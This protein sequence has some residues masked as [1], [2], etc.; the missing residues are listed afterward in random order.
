MVVL[1]TRDKAAHFREQIRGVHQE[2]L[3]GAAPLASSSSSIS[4]EESGPGFRRR[5]KGN[6][7]D[8]MV[9][10]KIGSEECTLSACDVRR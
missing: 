3:S 10:F 1:I 8:E 6:T 4:K 9:E 7:V 2:R 5:E